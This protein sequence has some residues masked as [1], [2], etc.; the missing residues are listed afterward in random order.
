MHS[1]IQTVLM[2]VAVAILSILLFRQCG[3]KPSHGGITTNDAINS[4]QHRIDSVM[5]IVSQRDSVINR[6]TDTVIHDTHTIDH[7]ITNYLTQ[8][9]TVF[10]LREC[11]SLVVASQK[12]SKDCLRND[13]LHRSQEADLKV[14]ISYYKSSL[15]TAKYQ[16]KS[17][18]LQI[19]KLTK[20]KKAWRN[21]TFVSSA[22]AF[23]VGVVIGSRHN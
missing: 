18:S 14:T 8:T 7:Y 17:D 3:S 4:I 5:T 19:A 16:L 20:Q 9:D 2:V 22:I 15:D 6:S 21:A 11:D 12:L 23:G 1:K 13:S 10:K